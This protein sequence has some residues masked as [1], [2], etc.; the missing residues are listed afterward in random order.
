MKPYAVVPVGKAGSAEWHAARRQGIGS[1]E[2]AT[3]LGFGRWQHP[4]GVWL[5]KT[6]DVAEDY[7]KRTGKA[8]A[9]QARDLMDAGHAFEETIARVWAARNDERVI[10]PPALL[11]SRRYPWMQASLDWATVAGPRSRT[12][13]APVECKLVSHGWDDWRNADGDL[14]V[15][16]YYVAQVW[17]QLVVLD[18]PVGH[19]AAILGGRIES[20]TVEMDE[21]LCADVA[22]AE[23][24]WWERHV[25]HG[26]QPA[27]D[28]V[29]DRALLDRAVPRPLR[30]SREATDVEMNLL[31][32]RAT[33]ARV[34]TEAKKAKDDLT[35]RLCAYLGDAEALTRDGAV[36]ATWR[37]DVNGRRA[38]TAKRLPAAMTQETAA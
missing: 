16:A 32:M 18:Q 38:F 1:S 21:Q 25:V 12:V 35:N 29:P 23:R 20:F 30:E 15:P 13:V 36:V 6:Q 27:P 9:A 34:E 31:A 2:A 4:L 37:P 3:V 28:P 11:R 26:E 33:N 10:R 24:V 8:H 17:H 19:V 5:D 22:E 14:A 7:D